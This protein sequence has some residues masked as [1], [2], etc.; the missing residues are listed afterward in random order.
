MRTTT[1]PPAARDEARRVDRRVLA[2]ALPA[3]AS[4]LAKPL[5]D[6]TD[7]A[8]LGHLGTTPLAGAVIATEILLLAS[9]I[10]IFLMFGTTAAVA[11]LSGAGRRAEAAHQGVQG[12]W[13]GAGLGVLVAA[14]LAALLPALVPVWGGH[15]EVAEAA[16][17]YGWISLLGFP[18]FL[19]G[20]AGTGYVRGTSDTV[21]PLWIALGTVVLNLVVEVTTVYGFGW[22]VAASAGSTVLA[23]WVGAIA[24]VVIVRRAA[25]GH[26]M[27]LRPDAGTL[28]GLGS[29]GVP[30]FVRTAAL[31]GTMAT[32]VALAG[33]LGTTAVAG[34]GV[35]FGIWSFLA[36]LSDGL[37][38]AGQVM[39]AEVLGQGDGP[40]A[41]HVA[42]RILRMSLLVGLAAAALVLATRTGLPH[43]FTGD[44]AVAAAAASGLL[45]VALAQPLNSVVF[46]AA[47]ILVGADDLRFLALAMVG[48]TAAYAATAGAVIATD[49]GITWVWAALVGF[50]VARGVGLGLRLRSSAWS[51]PAG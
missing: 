15:G 41:R 9:S 35:A 26:G 14:L 23:Q 7:T 47:G 8:I 10:F 38:V 32:S 46:A 34:Y 43:L 28:R 12:M 40:R 36:Y 42:L 17:T 19:M 31:R 22:G 2:L 51:A 11:R 27:P 25:L 1:T 24:Y 5:Y 30:L 18:A 6:L 20:M 45:W 50:M 4:L 49:A 44:P 48:A 33:R 37:E 29:T 16:R 13:L 21:T 39:V 3:T